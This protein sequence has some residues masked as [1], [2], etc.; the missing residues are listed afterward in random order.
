MWVKTFPF[1]FKGTGTCVHP[2][3][4]FPWHLFFSLFITQ[5]RRLTVSF[6]VSK[7]VL[8]HYLVLGWDFHKP[9]AHLSGLV[10]S[11]FLSEILS[12]SAE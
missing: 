12:R 7:K 6:I 5:L 2:A 1:P 11:G 8:V 9:P 10:L 4:L 3:F